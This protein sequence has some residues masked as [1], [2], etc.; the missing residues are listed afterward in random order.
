M[1]FTGRH[2]EKLLQIWLPVLTV[3]GGALWGLYTYLD[4]QKE[5]QRLLAIEVRKDAITRTVEARKPFLEKQLALYFE[6]AQ[7][8]GKIVTLT[9][10]DDEWKGVERR[11]WELYWSEL[12]MVE[13][14][15]V[16]EAMVKF[17]K[18]LY[19][20]T[21]RKKFTVTNVKEEELKRPL[22]EAAF[23]LA[24]AI[25]KSIENEW[26]GGTLHTQE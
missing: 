19:D 7:V 3:V 16:E 25:R 15:A 1:G 9:P 26:S 5:A 10:T 13:D 21:A 17:S 23:E 8:A 2:I 12:S 14:R 11:F 20:Y 18:K 24:H 6:T 4:H 22:F